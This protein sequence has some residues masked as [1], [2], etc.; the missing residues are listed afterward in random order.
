MKIVVSSVYDMILS[1]EPNCVFI[2][3]DILRNIVLLG[4]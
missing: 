1:L 2:D 4:L 3:G